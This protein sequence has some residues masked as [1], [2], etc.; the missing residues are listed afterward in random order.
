MPHKNIL[1][2]GA[3]RGLG[4]ALA[5]QYAEQEDTTVYGTTRKASAPEGDKLDGGIKWVKGIDVSEKS[6]GDDLVG[7][8]KE[9]A[10]GK[11]LVFEVV[12]S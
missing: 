9:L 8:L 2:I 12:V 11:G 6:V 7:G 1:I 3:T 10:D 4:A 5:N